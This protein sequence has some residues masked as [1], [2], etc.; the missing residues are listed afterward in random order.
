MVGATDLN[1]LNML[2]Q[3]ACDWLARRGTRLA[4]RDGE[5]IHSRGDRNAQMGI[6]IAGAVRLG[7]LRKDGG[8]TFTGLVTAGQHFGDVLMAQDRPRTHD[9]IAAGST[10][11]DYYDRKRFMEI[12]DNLEILRALYLI[13]A[14]RLGQTMA[15]HED[16]RG[17]SREAHLAK[18]LLQQWAQ[19]GKKKALSVIQDDLAA[20]I[21]VTPMTLSK[22]IAKLKRTGLI[23]TGYRQIR[24]LDPIGLKAWL[25][26]R[27]GD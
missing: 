12:L 17:L 16:L 22:G 5:L 7:R 25:Q 11:I 18:I 3:E 27:S 6:V 4:Y 10:E 15:M 21:G 24:I 20:L 19:G 23:E 1:L 2:S 14:G 26:E 8:R 13:T 9:A